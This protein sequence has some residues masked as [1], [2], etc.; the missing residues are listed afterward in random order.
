MS[1]NPPS[2]GINFYNANNANGCGVQKVYLS[3]NGNNGYNYSSNASNAFPASL[4]PVRWYKSTSGITLAAGALISWMDQS[5]NQDLLTPQ[6]TAPLFTP[7][8]SAFNG[9]PGID[10]A[11]TSANML[12]NMGGGGGVV[13]QPNTTYVVGYIL[14]GNNFADSNSQRQII[15]Y[16]SGWYIHAGAALTAATSVA[17]GTAVVSVF[18][19]IFNGANSSMIQNT[20]TNIIASGDASTNSYGPILMFG[21]GGITGGVAEFIIYKGIHTTA[22][23]SSMFKYF[24]LSY[25]GN[26]S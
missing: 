3:Q 20:S 14:T 4:S 11:S 5:G 22:Q 19:C 17:Y 23:I 16:A 25:G 1:F 21:N 15:G 26:F 6:G 8:D 13:S 9:L 7:F 10:P 12:G 24:A 18:A 2:P